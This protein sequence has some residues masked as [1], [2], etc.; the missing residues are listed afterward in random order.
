MP[1]VGAL[2]GCEDCAVAHLTGAGLSGGRG[3]SSKV[4]RAAMILPERSAS[5]MALSSMDGAA[6]KLAMIQ[7]GFI[8][9]DARSSKAWVVSA[10][11]RHMNGDESDSRHRLS[12]STS[13]APASDALFRGQVGI[14]RRLITAPEAT[15]PDPRPSI[16]RC[17]QTVQA[18]GEFAD[19]GRYAPLALGPFPGAQ[20]P[21]HKTVSV[22]YWQGSWPWSGRPAPRMQ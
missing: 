3:S 22:R 19:S 21:G 9:E 7:P 5:H 12:K 11:S 10:F 18:N 1:A 6:G 14:R 4:S 8:R 13:L 15:A 17:R 16:G 20:L 2:W